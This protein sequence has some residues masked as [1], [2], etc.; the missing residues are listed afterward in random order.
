MGIPID[1]RLKPFS[2][3]KICYYLVFVLV[4]PPKI[5]PLLKNQSVP[6]NSTFAIKCYVKGDPTLKVNWNKDGLDLGMK[7]NT[8]TIH[9]IAFEDAGWYGCTVKYWAGKIEASF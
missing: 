2:S 5:N 4:P 8:L 7:E 3:I 9:N 6:L 1:L